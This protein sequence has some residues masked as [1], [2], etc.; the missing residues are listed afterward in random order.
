MRPGPVT[1]LFKIWILLLLLLLETEFTT[2]LEDLAKAWGCSTKT[3]IIKSLFESVILFFNLTTKNEIGH[4]V[5]YGVNL[6]IYQAR[7]FSLVPAWFLTAQLLQ[8]T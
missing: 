8:K 7:E 5:T 4:A 1:S 2:Y 6:F 3:V